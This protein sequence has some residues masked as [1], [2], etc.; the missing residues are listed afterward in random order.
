MIDEVLPEQETK[1]A[2]AKNLL[3]KVLTTLLSQWPRQRIVGTKTITKQTKGPGKM[4]SR[5]KLRFLDDLSH[6]ILQLKI[7]TIKL[8]ENLKLCFHCQV[9]FFTGFWDSLLSWRMSHMICSSLFPVVQSSLFWWSI[10]P[11]LKKNH[12]CIRDSNFQ[13]LTLM[14]GFLTFLGFVL[15]LVQISFGTLTHSSTSWSKNNELVRVSP[16]T[17]DMIAVLLASTQLFLIQI[18][19]LAWSNPDINII[20]SCCWPGAVGRA[21]WHVY[22]VFVAQSYIPPLASH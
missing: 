12:S 10:T 19:F 9:W 5:V 13:L 15:D 22:T 14:T 3:G 18:L 6:R 11:V 7:F 8:P 16:V 17:V 20:F 21:W 2:V 4:V 1:A